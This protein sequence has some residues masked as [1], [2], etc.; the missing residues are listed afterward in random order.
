MINLLRIICFFC[1]LTLFVTCKSQNQ[2]FE[3]NTTQITKTHDMSKTGKSTKME[4]VF[5]RTYLGLI[6][7]DSVELKVFRRAMFD[8][9]NVLAFINIQGKQPIFLEGRVDTLN[10]D[11]PTIELQEMVIDV[12]NKG[13]YRINGYFEHDSAFTGTFNDKSFALKRQ[14]GSVKTYSASDLNDTNMRINFSLP[15][16]DEHKIAFYKKILSKILSISFDRDKEKL[17]DANVF[18]FNKLHDFKK[19][20]KHYD[21]NIGLFRF[22]ENNKIASFLYMDNALFDFSKAFAETRGITYN[23]ST[24]N[25][26]SFYDIF[27]QESDSKVRDI[28]KKTFEETVTNRN[29]TIRPDDINLFN[30]INKNI[31]VCKEG[32][33]FIY[34]IPDLVKSYGF[35][36]GLKIF[37]PFE[38]I[39]HLVRSDFKKLMAY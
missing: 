8:Q 2:K 5:D 15:Q 14:I 25:E 3:N 34:S 21:E 12:L 7:S 35:M 19:S 29:A 20:K 6:G 31:A 24:G 33:F 11:K 27:E 1:F 13:D 18:Y 22:F 26:L 28:V 23:L 16:Y 30:E 17:L 36:S 32:I 10:Y 4:S 39:N 38:R 37:V 9:F